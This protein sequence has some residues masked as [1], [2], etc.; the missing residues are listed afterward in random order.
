MPLTRQPSDLVEIVWLLR[1]AEVLYGHGLSE[2]SDAWRYERRPA[3]SSQGGRP[4][5]LPSLSPPPWKQE[6][7]L[8]PGG[9]SVSERPALMCMVYPA[10]VSSCL[11]SERRLDLG[12]AVAVVHDRNAFGPVLIRPPGPCRPWCRRV[13]Q[14]AI[15][16]RN[17]FHPVT[18][19]IMSRCRSGHL[20]RK[21]RATNPKSD[22][23]KSECSEVS[24]K[25]ERKGRERRK[26]G[27]IDLQ[28]LVS[29][30]YT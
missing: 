12:R 18:G 24:T 29:K 1:P 25:R 27:K 26:T 22:D 23:R 8:N 30:E 3:A 20:R 10:G 4:G 13:E 6:F 9:T 21:F 5:K 28:W 17:A 11:W 7:S 2:A 16:L 15:R 14:Y 19:I